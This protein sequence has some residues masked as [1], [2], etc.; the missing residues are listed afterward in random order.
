MIVT[1]LGILLVLPAQSSD[2]KKATL[3][4][5]AKLQTPKAAFKADLKSE[6]PT[7][8]ATS[9]ALRAIKYF[10]GDVSGKEKIAAFLL[11]CRDAESG[12]F[13]D[14]PGG[15]PDGIVTAV[16]LMALVEVGQPTDKTAP[17]SIDF[18]VRH[19]KAF[20]QIRMTAAGMEAVSGRSDRNAE[21]IALLAKEQ[22]D[23]GTFGKGNAMTRETGGKVAC[24][25]RLGGKVK[26]ADRIVRAL[27]AGQRADGGFGVEKSELETSYRVVRTYH[28]LGRR[29]ARAD[30]LRA[31][32]ASCRNP[33]G[34][35]GVAPGQPSSV[36]GTYFAGIILHWLASKS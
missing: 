18:M 28:M 25:L 3:D 32:I 9:S 14:S 4:Y 36:S 17:A 15:K 29:P 13:A 24:L 21:W 30:A 7:L 26:D 35:Y 12:G 1:L 8:R 33:D 23:D 22:N 2:E 5:L 16:A 10:G 34:G 6:G 20:E 11:S 31:F 19:A 27:D